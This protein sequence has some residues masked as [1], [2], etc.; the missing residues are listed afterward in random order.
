MKGRQERMA[1]LLE[2]AEGERHALAEAVADIRD[3]VER[4][5]LQW[6]IVSMVVTGLAAAGTVAYRLFGKTSLSAK[7]GRAASAVSLLWTLGRAYL[8]ERR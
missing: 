8:R 1:A 7:M 6:K 3:E 4:R 2:R 5:R